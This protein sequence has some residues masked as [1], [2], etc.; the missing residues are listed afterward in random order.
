MEK[1]GW[2]NVGKEREANRKYGLGEGG[3]E[4][5]DKGEE[6]MGRQLER[7]GERKRVDREGVVNGRNEEGEIG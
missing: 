3:G 1:L 6:R 2:E 7:T 5:V 4:R